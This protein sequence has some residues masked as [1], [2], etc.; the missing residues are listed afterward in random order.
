MSPQTPPPL[1]EPQARRLAV[2]L[3]ELE[4]RLAA[5]RETLDRPPGDLRLTSYQDR[6]RAEEADALRQRIRV[7]DGQVS[8]MAGT[9]GLQASAESVRR[10]FVAGL[11][12]ASITLYEAHPSGDLRGCGEVAPVTAAYLEA[13]LPRL[14]ASVREII[15][16]LERGAQA[17]V[18]Q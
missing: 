1:T 8:A 17:E 12:V 13:E 6:I 16:Q 15:R 18:S 4:R 7:A 10:R 2:T 5:L 11:E 14:E 3:A 9:L